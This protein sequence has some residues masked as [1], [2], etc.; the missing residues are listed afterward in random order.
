MIR[1]YPIPPV[2]RDNP[3]LDLLYTPMAGRPEVE[4]RRTRP[5]RRSL[6]A[7]L[8]T[9]APH[10]PSTV[11]HLHFFDEICQRPSR[12]E[13]A[14]RTAAFIALLRLLR[15]RGVRL[16]WSAHNLMPHEPYHP[17]LAERLYR[18]I[19]A[20]SHAVIAFSPPVADD[21]AARYGQP[22]HLA[23]IPH[24][25]YIGQRGPKPA[26]AEAR[27]RLHLPAAA[28]IYLCLGAWRPYKGLE[29]A[30]AA[31]AQLTDDSPSSILIIAG[32]PKVPGYA[33][34]LQAMADQVPGVRLIP[35]WVPD[36]AMASYW[37][38]ADVAVFAYRRLTNSGAL[39]EAMSYG[40]PVIAPDVPAVRELVR[41]GETGFLFAPGNIAGL[42]AAMERAQAHPALATLGQAALDCV[43]QFNWEA[44]ASQTLEVYQAVA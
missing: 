4:V 27:A 41:E 35:G 33:A 19:V 29:D 23:I 8:T 44:I 14:I 31:F 13:T 10:L 2:L 12:A 26:Q 16:V 18:R 9:P 36:E 28:F 6:L 43:R 22:R 7:L 25:H 17:D 34:L 5:L 21:L 37:A 24:G 42:H 39:I 15:R 1:V 38:A 32:Q 30:I 11:V 3:Y 20:L 40:L